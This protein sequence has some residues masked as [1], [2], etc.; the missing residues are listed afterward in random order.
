MISFN[1]TRFFKLLSLK[2]GNFGSMGMKGCCFHQG[3]SRV[4]SR[5]VSASA[6][7]CTRAGCLP[8]SLPFLPPQPRSGAS[9][10]WGGAGGAV[11]CPSPSPAALR[12]RLDHILSPPPMPLRK[13]SNPEVSAGPGKP[14][15]FKR[16]MSE[17]GRQLRRGSLGGALTGRY[18]LPN[19]VGQ[20]L[21]QP[22]ETSNLVRMRSQALG[23]S[24][25]SL[26][27]SWVS[28]FFQS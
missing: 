14:F 7:R 8:G 26:T 18:L 9:P 20:Q 21:W 5:V 16:Q 6:E 4:N 13:S 10:C 28:K 12:P 24:A 3:S 1:R 15:K 27:A 23:Q 2:I 22:A 25:P 17:D 11:S 19:A